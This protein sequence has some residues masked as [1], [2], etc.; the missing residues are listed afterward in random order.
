MQDAESAQTEL[1]RAR[2]LLS[3]LERELSE[4]TAAHNGLGLA[5]KDLVQH[6]ESVQTELVGTRYRPLKAWADLLV[7]R[8]LSRLAKASPP[9]SKRRTE[10]FARSAAKR[11][12]LRRVK[13]VD[14]NGPVL[15][16]G[17]REGLIPNYTDIASAVSVVAPTNSSHVP[18]DPP[19]SADAATYLATKQQV[20]GS[21]FWDERWYLTHHFREYVV[22]RAGQKT[23]N[24]AVDHYLQ[25]G[26]KA[27]YS[28]SRIFVYGGTSNGAGINPISDLLTRVW[29]HFHFSENTWLPERHVIQS[30]RDERDKRV[31]RK[32]VYC[33]IIGEYDS[34]IQ[35]YH[36]DHEWDYICF[37]DDARLI[38]RGEDGVWQFREALYPE[39]SP[40]RRNR[41][42][43]MHPHHLFP[44]YDESV[45]VDGN[46]NIISSYLFDEIR[47]R[48]RPILLPQ[49]FCR[50]CIYEEIE[51]LLRSTRTSEENRKLLPEQI[52]FLRKMGFPEGY[53]LT[54]N[55][56]IYRR[57]HDNTVKRI[58]AR[59][60]DLLCCFSSRDQ[61]ALSYVLWRERIDP[62]DI[63]FPNTRCLNT[64]FWVFEHKGEESKSRLISV[65][66]RI[67]PAFEADCVPVVLSCNE[68]FV[69]YLGVVLTSLIENASDDR[70]YDII[71]L[72]SD[73]SETSK[74]RIKT[75]CK[76]NVSIRFFNMR[77]ILA[78]LKDFDVYVEGYVPPETYNK[79]FLKEIM[80]GY[81]K[82]LYIDTDIVIR[83]DIAELY[84]T[85]L[86]G[87]ALGASP[88]VA[89][90]HAARQNTEI[91][92]NKFGD[93]LR[94][95]LGVEQFDHYFQA[96]IIV[97]DMTSEK[98]KNLLK[99]S[100]E[101]L[102]EIKQPVF[103]DQCI[104]NS[105]FYGDV[106]FFSTTWNHVWYLQNYSYLKYTLDDNL[107]FDY[108]KSRLDPKIIHYASG[109]KPTNK[110][111]WRLSSHF[112]AYLR[113]SPFA[114]S[115]IA[116]M[117]E[118][119]ATHNLPV[120]SLERL[121]S[122][123]APRVLVHL[124]AFYCDQL[125]YI[126]DKLEN[127]EFAQWDLVVTASENADAIEE[128]AKS[129][130]GA[131]EIV[132]VKNQG[133]DI[134]PF[135][136][137]LQAK[138]LSHYDYV[139]KLH[140]KNARPD[141]EDSKVYGLPVPG[142]K[143]RDDLVDALL[144]SKSVFTKNLTRLVENPALGCVAAGQYIFSINENRERTTYKLRHWMNQLRIETG[145]HYVG[146][147]MFL[148]RAYPFERLKALN[149][150]ELDFSSGD[151]TSGSHKN[152]AHVFERLL[153]LVVETEGLTLSPAPMPDN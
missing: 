15:K 19:A 102:K 115:L 29:P 14:H 124:H 51:A 150:D 49:H 146:G 116:E 20:L 53:G 117:E 23:N 2:D 75:L 25:V 9:F 34:I 127:I 5:H 52:D 120:P 41:Y 60:W 66:D 122:E 30:Y 128:V 56:V 149:P 73:V 32:V 36:I 113:R 4:L 81:K 135:L 129:R 28:P 101:K 69:S 40:D 45:Y 91:R 119:N 54:E 89:N 31:S 94:D 12:P 153:G 84:D 96:G 70:N 98:A 18:L 78:Q 145:E 82:V 123:P 144:S 83:S 104:F 3:T 72:E 107:F 132:R 143:W 88:N 68:G 139:L 87:K 85:D 58:M 16:Y 67:R 64:D 33:C 105:I 131:A 76:R 93:Y 35:P 142:Y 65:D 108:A 133:F 126:F 80:E 43:K 136:K 141:S 77:A 137:V 118:K 10:R 74:E 61:T 121:C 92:G 55:N 42:H 95:V 97:L 130:F 63:S 47:L 59:W 27:G 17:Y 100:L 46:V 86:F 57:H 62:Q 13:Y 112:W 114:D 48:K 103:F 147:T 38:E 37:T 6:V 109:D 21:G 110:F 39:M 111:D 11:D 22:W 148:A 1:V 138:N 79:I 99:L 7:F 152:L 151:V 106:H 134:Y 71:V 140:T 44:D 50:T 125:D 90:I 24:S 8:V 26:W